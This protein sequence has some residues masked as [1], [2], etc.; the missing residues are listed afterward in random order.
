MR[1]FQ[2]ALRMSQALSTRLA[3]SLLLTGAIVCLAS[4]L[5]VRAGEESPKPRDPASE[6]ARAA[7][8]TIQ[9]F[10]VYQL[11]TPFESLRGFP[12]PDVS[13]HLQ[14]NLM[15]NKRLPTGP[16]PAEGVVTVKCHSR[17]CGVLD[18]AVHQGKENG[19]IV[20]QQGFKT[21]KNFLLEKE[22]AILADEIYATLADE[23]DPKTP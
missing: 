22:P 4:G 9:S 10:E 6:A 17:R 13:M 5:P 2:G 15:R 12:A 20:W 18:V 19:P 16:S 14:M 7:L 23:Y 8:Q 11:H 21:S 1:A 3:L